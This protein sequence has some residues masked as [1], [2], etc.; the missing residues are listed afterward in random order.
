MMQERL[1]EASRQFMDALQDAWTPSDIRERGA[2][3]QFQYLQVLQEPSFSQVQQG[4]AIAY[5]NYMQVVQ[6][7]LRS[8]GIQ[9]RVAQ[10]Y[11]QYIRTVKD[12]WT[13]MDVDSVDAVT[14]TA[15]SQSMLTT[16]SIAAI[17][18]GAHEDGTA[19]T[20]WTSAG[21]PVSSG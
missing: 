20:A 7:A 15:I 18:Q 11:R 1:E 4:L 2:A 14:L 21:M 16:A 8:S 17:A 12:A 13:E 9:Q 3:A 6:D 19:A 10:A 5:A